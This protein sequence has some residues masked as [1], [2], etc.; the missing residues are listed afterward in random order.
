MHILRV[1]SITLNVCDDM[2]FSSSEWV[3]LVGRVKEDPEQL[4]TGSRGTENRH[5][6]G[7]DGHW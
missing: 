7:R 5:K 4:E 1:A 6:E 3:I 2:F